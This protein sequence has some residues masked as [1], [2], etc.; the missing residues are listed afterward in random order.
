MEIIFI[1]F[2][3]YNFDLT[4]FDKIPFISLEIILNAF[5]ASYLNYVVIF[6]LE[7]IS[8]NV[9]RLYVIHSR[10][11]YEWVIYVNY[12]AYFSLCNFFSSSFSFISIPYF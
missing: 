7:I 10:I 1:I 9:S 3:F 4:S 5:S 6:K 12:Y 8:K 11:Y 2:N